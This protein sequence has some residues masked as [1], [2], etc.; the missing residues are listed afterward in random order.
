MRLLFGVD[1][2]LLVCG[3]LLGLCSEQSGRAS[4]SSSSSC[5]LIGQITLTGRPCGGDRV[6]LVSFFEQ[7]SASKFGF[8]LPVLFA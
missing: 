7:K 6:A 5:P 3:I 2:L 4:E 1:E 8:C